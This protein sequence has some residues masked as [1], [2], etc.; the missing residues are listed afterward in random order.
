MRSI[1]NNTC[2][3]GAFCRLDRLLL[4]RGRDRLETLDA[5]CKTEPFDLPYSLGD[6]IDWKQSKLFRHCEW[7]ISPTR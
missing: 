4:A 5:N 6:A 7:L 2:G 3:M 1:G